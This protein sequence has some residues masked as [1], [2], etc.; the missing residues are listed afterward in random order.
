[1][2]W[3]KK[4]LKNRKFVILAAAG[5]LTG[6][7]LLAEF[8]MLSYSIWKIV[9]YV[10]LLEAMFL[11]AWIDQHDRKIPNKILFI[12]LLIRGISLAGEWLTHPDLGLAILISALLGLLIG[13]GIFLLAHFITRG[14]VGM[15]DVKLLAV[16]GAYMGVGSI[17]TVIFL[18]AVASAGYSIIMLILRKVKLKEEIPFAPFVLAGLILSMA[19]GM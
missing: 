12:L 16:I 3:L 6:A 9:R 19:L 5:A 1:M 15:G 13:G 7:L 10:V 18:T 11:T 4:Q 8:L 14:G 2:L 17:M